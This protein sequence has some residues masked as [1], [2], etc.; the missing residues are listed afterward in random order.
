M[1]KWVTV[2]GVVA[3]LVLVAGGCRALTPE[4]SAE[5]EKWRA[6]ATAANEQARADAAKL[7]DLQSKI[8][9]YEAKVAAGAM[10][11]V[12]GARAISDLSAAI[13]A[14]VASGQV[15]AQKADAASQNVDAMIASGVPGWRVALE[16]LAG[17]IGV[18]TTIAG[19]YK[20]KKNGTLAAERGAAVERIG[21]VA[22]LVV[23]TIEGIADARS[24]DG[25][26]KVVTGEEIKAAVAKK[27]GAKGL[28]VDVDAVV[29][30]LLKGKAA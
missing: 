1:S 21:T 4:Q 28:S 13:P 20:A 5:V 9:E 18:T 23:N 26:P 3:L 16:V 24:A 17:L 27:A 8:K 10:S 15:W 14:L 30:N 29:Q 12:E 7:I 6:E 25:G 2:V 19:V 22:G 11:A